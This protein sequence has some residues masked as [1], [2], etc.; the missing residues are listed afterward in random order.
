[1]KLTLVRFG[2]GQF[3]GVS[4]L[5]SLHC[6]NT[7]KVTSLV[8]GQVVNHMVAGKRLSHAEYTEIQ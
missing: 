5:F 2:L 8:I 1:M 4:R 3:P 7:M 6:S